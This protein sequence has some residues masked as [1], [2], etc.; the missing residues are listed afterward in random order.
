MPLLSLSARLRGLLE[1]QGMSAA[2]LGRLLGLV[3]GMGSKLLKG[4]RRLTVEHIHKLSTRF[5]L[6]SDYFLGN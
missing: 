1:A 2:D 6:P 4:D 3:P 5:G